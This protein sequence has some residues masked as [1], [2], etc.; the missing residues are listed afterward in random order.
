MCGQS[1][2]NDTQKPV[3][4]MPAP[5]GFIEPHAGMLTAPTDGQ[6]LFKVMKVEDLLRSVSGNYLYFNRVDLYADFPE[7][8]RHDGEQLP[9]DRPA[10]QATTFVRAPDFSLATYY[11]QA[12][13]RTYASCFSLENTPELWKRQGNGSAVGKVCVVFDFA[14]LRALLNTTFASGDVALM[15][16]DLRLRQIFSINYGVVKYV[17][18]NEHR[19]NLEHAANPLSYTYVK[20]KQYDDERELRIALSAMGVGRYALSNGTEIEFPRSLHVGFDFKKANADGTI[21]A[22]LAENDTVQEFLEARLRE[23]GVGTRREA[24]PSC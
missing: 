9:L 16:G 13:S 10:N 3:V 6:L 21:R 17:E 7:A 15:H 1:D 18:W 14:K 12:R 22:T 23:L 24:E 19:V 11:D 20:S 8:D 4:G 2:R 5:L